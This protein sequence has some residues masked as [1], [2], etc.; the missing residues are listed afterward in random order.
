[1]TSIKEYAKDFKPITALR[2][3]YYLYI[4]SLWVVI[5]G[6]VNGLFWVISYFDDT[7]PTEFRDGFLRWSLYLSI[8]L[9]AL[10][11]LGAWFYYPT[12][13]YEVVED[14]IHV[15]VGLITKTRKVV[16]Y[17]TITNIEVKQGPYDRLLDIGSVEIQTAGNSANKQGPEEKLEGVPNKI[18][19]ELQ[20]HI[21]N[22]V[23]KVIGS[24]GTSH[25]LD[26]VP[27]GNLLAAIL[28]E[29]K[30]LRSNLSK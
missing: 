1:M 17:R 13:R 27:E 3:K 10:A 24:P 25:D 29:I 28:E 2:T 9:L 14:E 7:F 8:P 5:I 21:I 30:L 6:P 15:F 22:S 26:K 19:L 4:I 23:R 11:F 16:P 12:L 18:L 20:E